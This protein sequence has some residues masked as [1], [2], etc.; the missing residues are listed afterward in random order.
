MLAPNSFDPWTEVHLGMLAWIGLCL[1]CLVV[2]ASSLKQCISDKK[3]YQNV[4]FQFPRG[5]GKQN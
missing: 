5:G 4:P 3:S 2:Q 1:I